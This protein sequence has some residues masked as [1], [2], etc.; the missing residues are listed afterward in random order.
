M[1]KQQLENTTFVALSEGVATKLGALPN[2]RKRHYRYTLARVRVSRIYCSRCA[3]RGVVASGVGAGRVGAA[4][5]AQPPLM[6]VLLV[7]VAVFRRIALVF[8]LLFATLD[9]FTF[10][11]V[12]LALW[13]A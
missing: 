3:F 1:L 13:T 9:R 7:S 12:H 2:F 4:G 8:L 5:N 6:E 10:G 11:T